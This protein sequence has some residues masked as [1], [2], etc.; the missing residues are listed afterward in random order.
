[1][2]FKNVRRGI[3]IIADADLRLQP[4]ETME[5]DEVS[6]ETKAAL[7]AGHLV[8]IPPA[9]P[10]EHQIPEPPPEPP[11]GHADITKLSAAEAIRLIKAEPDITRLRAWSDIDHR[12]T[13]KEALATRLEEHFGATG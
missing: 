5:V 10:D 13:V 2:R 3:L 7:K 6:K 4:G 8:L 12:R 11:V 1:M 9:D